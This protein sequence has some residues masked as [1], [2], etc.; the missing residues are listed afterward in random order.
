MVEEDSR[1]QRSLVTC[2]RSPSQLMS[3][4]TGKSNL[5]LLSWKAGLYHQVELRSRAT[6]ISVLLYRSLATSPLAFRFS[7]LPSSQLWLTHDFPLLP[8]TWPFF[9]LRPNVSPHLASSSDSG[10]SRW[11]HLAL[12]S[13]RADLCGSSQLQLRC[14]PSIQSARASRQNHMVPGLRWSWD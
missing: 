5:D 14:S 12:S 10:W 7:F 6:S 2:L 9:C 1:A 13:S 3:I 11:L 8:L 4:R